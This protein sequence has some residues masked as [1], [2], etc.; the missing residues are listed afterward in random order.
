MNGRDLASA[1]AD[2]PSMP[3]EKP[4]RISLTTILI[5]GQI[6]VMVCGFGGMVYALGG[7]AEQISM[8]QRDIGKLAEAASDLARTQASAAVVD[9]VHNKTIEDI[10]RRLDA[11]ERRTEAR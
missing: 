1:L 8:S 7:K 9:A 4:P 11:I 5:V 6:A 10:Q 3:E 2:D